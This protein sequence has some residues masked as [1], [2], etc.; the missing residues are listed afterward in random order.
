MSSRSLSSSG[1]IDLGLRVAK[2]AV[3]LQHCW[4]LLGEHQPGVEHAHE[5]PALGA[6]PVHGRLQDGAHDFGSTSSGGQTGAG[7]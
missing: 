5:R 3:E 6:Q 2:A 1:R 4:P 7:A